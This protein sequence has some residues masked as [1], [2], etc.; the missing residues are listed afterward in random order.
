MGSQERRVFFARPALALGGDMEG[1]KVL[2]DLDKRPHGP[3]CATLGDWVGTFLDSPEDDLGLRTGFVWSQPP[4]L[5]DG[6]AARTPVFAILRHIS[7]A[8]CGKCHGAKTRERV[9]PKEGAI[10]PGFTMQS[11]DSSLGDATLRHARTL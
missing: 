4:V 5:A 8:A 7:L 11:V 10:F 9:I 3:S 6:D 2:R 1:K